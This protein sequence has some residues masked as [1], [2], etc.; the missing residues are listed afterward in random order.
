MISPCAAD[1]GTGAL[2]ILRNRAI[3]MQHQGRRP[4]AEY[5]T[6]MCMVDLDALDERSQDCTPCLPIQVGHAIL[7]RGHKILQLPDYQTK[8]LLLG[9]RSRFL[10]RLGFQRRNALLEA[11]DPR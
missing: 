5:Y 10:R 2:T 7:D 6:D 11:P 3:G 9:K 1:S 4:H 8:T